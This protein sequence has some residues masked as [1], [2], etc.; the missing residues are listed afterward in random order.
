M[1]PGGHTHP[2]VPIVAP[3]TDKKGNKG[4]GLAKSTDSSCP[5]TFKAFPNPLSKSVTSE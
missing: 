1:G 3:S 2:I 5:A 4:A